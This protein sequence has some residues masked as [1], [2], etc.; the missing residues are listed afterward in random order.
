MPNLL[1]LRLNDKA[2]VASC[3]RICTQVKAIKIRPFLISFSTYGNGQKIFR[4]C[5]PSVSNTTCEMLSKM[6]F[7]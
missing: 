2:R 4:A 7:A 3:G 5:A 6:R 1:S